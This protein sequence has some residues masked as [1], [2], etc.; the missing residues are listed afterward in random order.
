MW[1]TN[2]TIGLIVLA[3]LA[4][5]TAVANIIP[6]VE[7]EVPSELSLSAD[8]TAEGL[9]AA[10]EEV[11][12]GAGGCMACHG[13]RTRAPDV[14]DVVG[15]TCE[16]RRPSMGCKEY[17]Y[18]SLTDPGAYLVEGFQPIMPDM[19]RTLSDQQIWA[20]VAFLQAQGGEVTVTADDFAESPG[21]SE[22]STGA[23]PSAGGG[24]RI[25]GDPGDPR[26]LLRSAGCL[27]CHVLDGEGGPV[28]PPFDGIGAERDAAYLRG[29]ILYP[30]A[31]TA[32]GY[33]T[34]AGTMPVTFGEQL[35]A[36]QLEAIVRFLAESR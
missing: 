5:Y 24:P 21:G 7:S 3:T 19:R 26:A 31:D 11:Y 32:Q 28:G 2:L 34:F 33:E 8:V 27:A 36:A 14:L 6:Q 18:E 4:T 13:L 10:G 16:T 29:S 25:A 12:S 17:L 22:T 20:T 15:H 35:T 9:V 1:R 23:G 30:N